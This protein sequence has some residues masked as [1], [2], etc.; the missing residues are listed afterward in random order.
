MPLL[1]C[2]CGTDWADDSRWFSCDVCGT[3]GCD[4]CADEFVRCSHLGCK[5]ILH[6]ECAAYWNEDALCLQH[7]KPQIPERY[8]VG[9]QERRAA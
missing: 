5:R 2:S 8:L 6:L 7:A 9:Y 1:K 3:D 4:E